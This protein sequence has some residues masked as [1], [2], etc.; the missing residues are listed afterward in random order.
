MIGRTS[1]SLP[2][3]KRAPWSCRASTAG[4]GPGPCGISSSAGSV[5]T[6]STI[7]LTASASDNVGVTKVEF[8]VDGALSGSATASPWQWALDSTKLTN[9]S[10]S[11]VV[12]AF[13]AAG[14]VGTSGAVGFTVSNTTTVFMSEKESNGTVASANG[15]SA[16]ITKITGTMGSTTDK[17]FFAVPLK[18]GQT[19]SVSM[20]GPNDYDLY[21]VNASGTQLAASENS[22]STESVSYK[23]ASATTVYIKVISYSG[24]STT[25]VYTLTLS[26]K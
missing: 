8:W 19:L 5:T 10:H 3:S 20:T 21:L 13:D 18:A 23:A 1:F 11:L 16:G 22:N 12:K 2:M 24:S 26:V 25:Q 4:C 17:D 15:V 7:T 14:N 9:G 6:A